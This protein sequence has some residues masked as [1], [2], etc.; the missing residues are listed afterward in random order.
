[1]VSHLAL[2]VN[3]R[4]RSVL[5]ICI[6]AKASTQ[7]V[8][9]MGAGASAANADFFSSATPDEIKSS[10]E[11]LP[12]EQQA[13]FLRMMQAA[14]QAVEEVAAVSEVAAKDHVVSNSES[15]NAE[16]SQAVEDASAAPEPS[17]GTS[18]PAMEEAPA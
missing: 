10:F 13:R 11:A 12:S 4:T 7:F 3:T 18:A 15:P 14:D 2:Q 9:I 6:M 17:A 16:Q 1:M 5:I 8:D